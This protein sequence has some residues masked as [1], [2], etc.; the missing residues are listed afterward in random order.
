MVR[1]FDKSRKVIEKEGNPRFYIRYLVEL[2]DYVT[3]VSIT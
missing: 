2:E 1:A 3:A